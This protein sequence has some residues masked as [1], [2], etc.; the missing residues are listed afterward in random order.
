MATITVTSPTP[1][2]FFLSPAL[3]NN[4]AEA[5]KRFEAVYIVVRDDIL[6]TFRQ[7]HMP[8]EVIEYCLHVRPFT[9][10]SA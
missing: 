5:R 3:K 10:S 9:A 8:E 1:C 2:T 4:N 7:H 6:E